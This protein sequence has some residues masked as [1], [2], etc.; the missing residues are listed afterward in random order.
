MILSRTKRFII[1]KLFVSN[2]RGL[3]IITSAMR[4]FSHVPMRRMNGRFPSCSI[5][6]AKTISSFLSCIAS[7]K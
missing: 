1:K 7:I 2:P 6:E 4:Q 5:Y 3:P